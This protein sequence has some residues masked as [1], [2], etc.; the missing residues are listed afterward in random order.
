LLYIKPYR[1]P[2]AEDNDNGGQLAGNGS[3]N[4]DQF[5]KFATNDSGN[6]NVCYMS[7]HNEKISAEISSANLD[8]MEVTASLLSEAIPRDYHHCLFSAVSSGT[9]ILPHHG[10]TNKKLRIHLPI[11]V[12]SI[13]GNDELLQ[14]QETDDGVGWKKLSPDELLEYDITK[15]TRPC[16]RA[17]DEIIY[18][19]EGE[20]ALLLVL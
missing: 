8:N 20:C 18:F 14:S 19:R 12:P 6:W 9:H 2:P 16:L 10:P 1:G 15:E 17:H 13:N 5:G 3:T 7:L 4:S 11:I